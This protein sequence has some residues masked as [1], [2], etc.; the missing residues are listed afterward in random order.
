V[1]RVTTGDGA[2]LLV[3]GEVR[4]ASV[5]CA[6]KDTELQC[7]RVEARI[8]QNT[9]MPVYLGFICQG[10]GA[11]GGVHKASTSPQRGTVW[12]IHA[13]P[14]AH[15]AVGPAMSAAQ[16][17]GAFSHSPLQ[18]TREPWMGH[19]G[20]PP[21]SKSLFICLHNLTGPFPLATWPMSTLRHCRPCG[22]SL[23]ACIVPGPPPLAH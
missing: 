1:V 16:I 4:D 3:L 17:S 20:T 14:A 22:E 10:G 8:V 7:L 23:F 12:V 13:L 6:L 15:T 19:D 2:P 11:S 18:V 21:A 9:P 5:A